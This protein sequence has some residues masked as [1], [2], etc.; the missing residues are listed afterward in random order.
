MLGGVT[1]R[2]KVLA[3]KACV[4]G[5]WNRGFESRPLRQEWVE[6]NEGILIYGNTFYGDSGRLG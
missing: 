6:R 2:P 3:W 1:E 5:N 4:L